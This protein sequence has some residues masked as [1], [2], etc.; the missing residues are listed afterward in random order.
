M[1]KKTKGLLRNSYSPGL[2]LRLVM[3]FAVVASGL[4]AGAQTPQTITSRPAYTGDVTAAQFIADVPGGVT[5]KVS[6]VTILNTLLADTNS[7]LATRTWVLNN[8]ASGT[9]TGGAVPSVFGRTGAVTAL[10]SDYSA[11][12]GTLS[13]QTTNTA[14]ITTIFSY[15]NGSVIKPTSLPIGSPS[16]LGAYKVG[17]GLAVAGDGT[18]SA[19]G[20]GAGSGVI[21]NY[22]TGFNSWG[23]LVGDSIKVASSYTAGPGTVSASDNVKTATQKLDGNIQANTSS[24]ASNTSGI[25]TNTSNIGTLSSL[26][27]TAKSSLVAAINEVNAKPGGTGYTLN[28]LTMTGAIYAGSPTFAVTGGFTKVDWV[29]V[30]NKFGPTYIPYS[31]FTASG[32]NVTLTGVSLQSGDSVVI[33]SENGV[34]ITGG[35]PATGYVPTYQTNGTVAWAAQTGSGGTA[36]DT[37]SLSNRINL[38]LNIIDT[39]NMLSHYLLQNV[40][41]ATYQPIGSYATTSQLSSYAPLASPSL[42]GVP[43]AP[44]PT[45]GDNTTKLATTAFVQ[46]AIA[47]L[48]GGSGPTSIALTTS[49][50]LYSTPVNFTN[51]SDAWSGA[52]SLISQPAASIFG[53]FTNASA[54]PIFTAASA[55]GQLLVR[56]SGALTF[57]T[58]VAGDIPDISAT[59]AKLASNN[60]FTGV[61]TFTETTAAGSGSLAGNAVLLNQTW[62]TTGNPTAFKMNITNTGSGSTALLMDLQVGS[63][64]KFSVDKS[65]NITTPALVAATTV[66]GSIIESSSATAGAFYAINSTTANTTTAQLLP[67]ANGTVLFRRMM[68]ATTGGAPLNGQ[69]FVGTIFGQEVSTIP[70]TGTVGLIAGSAFIA[71]SI[72]SGAG[73][74]TEATNVFI[75]DA[76]SNGVS[77]YALHVAAGR[78]RLDGGITLDNTITALGTDGAQTIN[79]PSGTVNIAASGTSVVV[80]NSFVTTSSI[81][82][83]VVR[84]A[85][86]TAKIRNVVPAAGSF[87]VNLDTATTGETSIGFIVIN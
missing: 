73:T 46:A 49:N 10:S 64:S 5:R 67:T 6:G 43:I 80:T 35:I 17:L 26:T 58:L 3:L 81:V 15:Y 18:L 53:N 60:T 4:A 37:T 47:G 27:T 33:Q 44:T 20:A 25:A 84:T 40:A 34:A 61:N 28:S 69:D 79:K 51:T 87:T 7:V 14:N 32:N 24:I 23:T 65:G 75:K 1:H 71:P 78:T 9:G 8:V 22:L 2:F 57:G 48:S 54:T 59:Y 11:F 70:A 29:Q 50:V 41:A 62:N 12:Y 56:R 45:A 16:A 72:T 68:R 30:W 66:Q 42:T 31:A 36:I 77:N 52:L 55:D 85:D 83:C 74:L 19:T 82:Y 63:V 86:A 38:K 21:Q 39:A 76:P 13:A